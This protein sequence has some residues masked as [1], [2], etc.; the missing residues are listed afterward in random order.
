MTHAARACTGAARQGQG[1]HEYGSRR[2]RNSFAGRRRAG[3]QRAGQRRAGQRR[4]G[5][6]RVGDATRRGGPARGYASVPTV[7][8]QHTRVNSGGLAREQENP[9]VREE[10]GLPN[11]SSSIVFS[12]NSMTPSSSYSSPIVR[13]RPQHLKETPGPSYRVS[14]IPVCRNKITMAK[15]TAITTRYREEYPSGHSLPIT[16]P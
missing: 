2:R 9:E 7:F 16:I 5:R 15:L 6:Q 12:H 1:N 3:R 11:Q 14:S 13:A 10:V 4:A 8:L